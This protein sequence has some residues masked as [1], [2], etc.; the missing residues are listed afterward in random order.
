MNTSRRRP[1]LAA[2]REHC[3][4]M[5][6]LLSAGEVVRLTRIGQ[7]NMAGETGGALALLKR[8]RGKSV[9]AAARVGR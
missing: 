4:A 3:D 7:F 5:L 1:A 6:C 9:L 2:R 8:L